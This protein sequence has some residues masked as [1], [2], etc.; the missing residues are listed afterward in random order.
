MPRVAIQRGLWR[1]VP[2]G[3]SCAARQASHEPRRCASTRVEANCEISSG[4]ITGQLCA[5]SVAR[6]VA[7]FREYGMCYFSSAQSSE[8]VSVARDQATQRWESN[9][10]R[11]PGG[12]LL[13]GMEHGYSGLVHRAQ[14]CDDTAIESRRACRSGLWIRMVLKPTA[15]VLCKII[16]VTICLTESMVSIPSPVY[17]ARTILCSH[18]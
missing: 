5:D 3:V 16:V 2:R 6:A 7:V 10:S 17:T 9:L 15:V 13:V 1:V 18:C 14:G 11:L 8:W 4:L 12:D